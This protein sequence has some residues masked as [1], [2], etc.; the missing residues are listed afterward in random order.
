MHSDL[1]DIGWTDDHWNR[2]CATVTEEAQKVRVAAQLLPVVGPEDGSVVA[3]PN[4]TTSPQAAAGGTRLSVDSDPTLYITRIAVNVFVRSHE[5]ADPKLSAV[6]QMFR[7]AANYIARVEDSLVFW[8]RRP[9]LAVAAPAG[10]APP[11][12]ASLL[13]MGPPAIQPVYDFTQDNHRVAGLFSWPPAPPPARLFQAGRRVPPGGQLGDGIVNVIVSAIQTLEGNGF[14][15]PFSC[16]LG[17]DLFEAICSPTPNLV[18]PRDRILP[19]LQGPLLRS[20]A[21]N[22]GDGLVISLSGNPI[23]LVVAS[24]LEVS[25]LQTSQEPR[26]VLRVSE[27]VALRIKEPGAVQPISM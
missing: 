2:I 27:R 3:I 23:E 19:F 5:A 10:A 13:N 17:D 4:F 22:W 12:P 16:V 6:L 7:R 1:V 9:G 8:G 20:S 21:V 14:Y 15:G 24:D 25:Y 11:P 18:L 26:L